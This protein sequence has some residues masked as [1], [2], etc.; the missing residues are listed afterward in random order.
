MEYGNG[1]VGDMCVHMLDAVR[2]MLDL[3]W[4]K[5][6]TSTGGIYVQKESNSNISDTQTAFFEYDELN[7][8]WEHRSW[9][10]PADSDYPWA[11]KIYGE[12]GVLKGDVNKYEFENNDGSIISGT[13]LLE[14]KEFPEDLTEKGI[15]MRAAPATRGHM[16]NWLAAIADG[17]K[18]IADIEQG[19][20]SSASCIIANLSMKTGDKLSYNPQLRVFKNNPQHNTLLKREYRRGYNHPEKYL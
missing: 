6:V 20:I 15:E 19:F 4:P 13:V 17:S 7:I 1:I 5:S 18:P 3:G 9:G 11:F 14:E 2:W 8:V 12:N 16:V 10:R